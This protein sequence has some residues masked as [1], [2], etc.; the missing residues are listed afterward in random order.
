LHRQNTATAASFAGK[1]DYMYPQSTLARC[2]ILPIAFI[3]ISRFRSLTPKGHLSVDITCDSFC[4]EFLGCLLSSRCGLPMAA[5][6]SQRRN[7]APEQASSAS[8]PVRPL[9]KARCKS[10]CAAQTKARSIA[11][12]AA[13]GRSTFQPHNSNQLA[14]PS[15]ITTV[16]SRLNQP[17]RISLRQD[18]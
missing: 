11:P 5:R 15:S 10:R 7:A 16:C 17:K 14:F 1:D 2:V 9:V 3:F 18:V 12:M 6:P 4:I 8:Q 13:D